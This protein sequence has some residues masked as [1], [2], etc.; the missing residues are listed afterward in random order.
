M[1]TLL[2]AAAS[3]NS[4]VMTS[5][6]MILIALGA[7]CA[8]AVIWWGTMRRRTKALE[9]AE[10]EKHAALAGHAPPAAREPDALPETDTAPTPV[11]EALADIPSAVPP[12]APA[13]AGNGQ[14][15]TRLKGLGPKAA[16]R[17][18]ELEVTSVD[19]LAAL[20]PAQIDAIDAQLGSLAGRIARDRWVE[21]AR[22]LA[23]GDVPGFEAAFGKLGG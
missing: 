15:L 1:T 19:Q 14:P 23:A 22:L 6:T 10:A 3:A 13:E 8:L 4:A 12:P 21:Q 11:I 18:A 17:L 16:A 5:F 2:S 20:S 7:V 9:I